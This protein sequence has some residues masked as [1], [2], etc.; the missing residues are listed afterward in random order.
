MA[1]V[2]Y[3]KPLHPLIG[4][5]YYDTQNQGTGTS[6]EQILISS[7]Y[8]KSKCP[9]P[10]QLIMYPALRAAWEEYLVIRKLL[11]L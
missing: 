10:K 8:E 7:E 3:Y 11:G 6:W 1:N 5:M 4:D 2:T 9:T